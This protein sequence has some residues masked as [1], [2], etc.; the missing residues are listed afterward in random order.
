MNP[1][2]QKEVHKKTEMNNII[3]NHRRNSKQFIVQGRAITNNNSGI[4]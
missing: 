1:G 3:E 4:A 2:I